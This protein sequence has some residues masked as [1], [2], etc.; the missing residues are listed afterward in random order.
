M[1]YLM[2][3]KSALIWLGFIIYT[4]TTVLMVSNILKPNFSTESANNSHGKELQFASQFILRIGL[5][6]PLL[7]LIKNTI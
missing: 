4:L 7:I 3:D 6:F 2:S 1:N 5:L